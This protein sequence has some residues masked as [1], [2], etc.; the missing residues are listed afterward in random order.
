[1]IVIGGKAGAAARTFAAAAAVACAAAALAA[2]SGHSSPAPTATVTT[3][4]PASQPAAASTSAAAASAPATGPATGSLPEYQPSTEVTKSAG[5]TL[6]K[7]PDSVDKINAFYKNALAQGGWDVISASAGP[8]HGS[9]TV[10]RG[11]EG[12]TI[13][14]YPVGSGSEISVSTHAT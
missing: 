2:C 3:T 7:S 14:V 10:D 6:L 1:M 8:Y 5:Y 4:A 13:S 9:F 12:A 11:S